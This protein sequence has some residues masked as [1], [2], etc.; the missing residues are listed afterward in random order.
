MLG[1][2]AL[3]AAALDSPDGV[4]AIMAPSGAGKSTL[5][6]ELLRQGWPL[7]ADD[8]LTLSTAVKGGS[9]P[10]PARRT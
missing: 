6:L 10:I 5:A 1:H 2:E 8:V 7:F 9:A 4:V 3:H